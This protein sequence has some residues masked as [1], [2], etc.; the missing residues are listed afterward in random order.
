MIL[1]HPHSLMV[2][3]HAQGIGPLLYMSEGNE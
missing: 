1:I 2:N 3:H